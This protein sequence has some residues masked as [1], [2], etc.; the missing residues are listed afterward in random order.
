MYVRKSDSWSE[1]GLL[2]GSLYK[3]Y[4]QAIHNPYIAS[5]TDKIAF[6]IKV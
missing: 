2:A 3:G 4:A 1:I 6:L 5:I